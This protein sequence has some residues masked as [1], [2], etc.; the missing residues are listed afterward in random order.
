M[1]KSG[2]VSWLKTSPRVRQYFV[3]IKK[4]ITKQGVHNVIK[5]F[6]RQDF[7]VLMSP[8]LSPCMNG[9]PVA[10]A[11]LMYTRLHCVLGE[12]AR[13]GPPPME[14]GI[15]YLNPGEE[16]QMVRKLRYNKQ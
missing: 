1:L 7:I 3:Q 11:D 8:L 12:K 16:S 4:K 5:P 2:H 14:P 13:T 9:F 15:Q 6:V 10:R